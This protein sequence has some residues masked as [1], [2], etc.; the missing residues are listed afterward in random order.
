MPTYD[1][2][3]SKCK[4]KYEVTR[5]FHEKGGDA[6]PACGGEGKF[7]YS[8]PPLIFKGGGFYVTETRKKAGLTYEGEAK[9][10]PEK[11]A[12]A[13]AS[14]KSAASPA[15]EKPASAPSSDKPSASSDATK[16]PAKSE[17]SKSESSKPASDRPAH[18][19]D[20]PK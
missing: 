1:Y 13:P 5:G 11:P 20:P 17:S 6:C 10:P 7:I 9:P 8:S 19:P 15:G 3:C 4:S 12:A 14:E 16:T 18:K 2:E